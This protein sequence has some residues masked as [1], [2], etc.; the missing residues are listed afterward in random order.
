MI[1]APTELH[2]TIAD[3]TDEDHQNMKGLVQADDFIAEVAVRFLHSHTGLGACADEP[4]GAFAT[5][6]PIRRLELFD[7]FACVWLHRIRQLR[8]RNHLQYQ[9][10]R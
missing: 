5:R 1:A 9:G 2:A 10:E 3:V 6:S 4:T 8:A 7:R